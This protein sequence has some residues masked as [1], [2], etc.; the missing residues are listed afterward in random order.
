MINN[1]NRDG[2]DLK[3]FVSE[4]KKLMLLIPRRE[5]KYCSEL[6]TFQAGFNFLINFC[7]MD[8]Q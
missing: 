4:L 6:I 3:H 8:F 7:Y 5:K 2:I 1:R